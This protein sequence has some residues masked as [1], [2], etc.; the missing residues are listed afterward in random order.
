MTST[1]IPRKRNARSC[2]IKSTRKAIDGYLWLSDDA[3]AAGKVTFASRSVANSGERSRLG[4]ELSRIIQRERLAKNGVTADQA[5][6]LLKPIKV[7]A[8]R[9]EQGRETK[10]S[11]GKK[12][13]EVVVMV[14]LIYVAVLLYG[15][16]V[17]RSVLEEKN[18]RVIEVLLSSATSTELMIGKIFGVG[19]VGLTQIAV[20]AVMAGVLA[21]PS[22]AMSI[23]LSQLSVS[24]GVLVAFVVFFLL[25]Y[26]LFSALY[27]AIGAITTT[28]QEGQQLQFI[29]V[30]PLVLSV[31]MLSV[32][33][34]ERPMLPSSFG[35]RC[36][37]SSRRS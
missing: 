31:F 33:G 15:I 19:A 35:C 21:L 17:M 14:M 26:L 5:D 24:P 18:S 36:F 11:S 22:L 4:E 13:L 7:D 1:R 8:I 16:S 28:E 32:R 27:A 9:I 6:L 10:D 29:V 34:A 23:D 2:A 3:I 25:G 37:P 12:F 20:W 30:I